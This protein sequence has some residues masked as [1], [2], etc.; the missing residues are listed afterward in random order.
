MIRLWGFRQSVYVRTVRMA[1][2][3]RAQSYE[4]IE[5]DP[6]DPTQS[7]PH[8]FGRVPLMAHESF[9]LYE[10]A[11][12]TT[13]IEAAFPGDA[14]TPSDPATR[15][16]I[17]QAI[18]IIDSYGYRPM[19]HDVFAN[20]AAGPEQ[21]DRDRLSRGLKKAAP[22][23][24]E[25]ETIAA[26]NRILNGTITRADLHIAPMLDYF[27]RWPDAA[28]M[29]ADRPTLMGW[30]TMIRARASFQQ[31]DPDQPTAD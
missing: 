7:S 20:T 24:D 8:P 3:E 13:Y 31:T 30:F 27:A 6:F 5:V 16:R 15:A 14:W 18:G 29:L 26:E 19:V 10:T 11:A 21:I 22:V 2:A 28:A 9:R 12:I 17:A 4:L 23:L 25:L 1:L